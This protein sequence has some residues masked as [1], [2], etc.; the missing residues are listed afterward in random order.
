MS[1]A[2]VIGL[3]LSP[4]RHRDEAVLREPGGVHRI[5]FTPKGPPELFCR[6]RPTGRPLIQTCV[7]S[8]NGFEA[9][10]V[11]DEAITTPQR[12]FERRVDRQMTLRGWQSARFTLTPIRPRPCA[13]PVRGLRRCPR[14]SVLVG[15]GLEAPGP[16]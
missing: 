2:P 16:A 3:D 15:T 10:L 13:V 5:H 1:Q 12:A 11:F 9:K 14:R 4:S 6:E 7:A 8:E